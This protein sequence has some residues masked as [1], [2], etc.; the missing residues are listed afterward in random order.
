MPTRDR[1]AAGPA[2]DAAQSDE[3]APCIHML[4]LGEALLSRR[5]GASMSRTTK[6]IATVVVGLGLAGIV[7]LAILRVASGLQ[8]KWALAA[9]AAGAILS[10]VTAV[11]SSWVSHGGNPPPA[12]GQNQTVANSRL[13]SRS[14]H[15]FA[16][17]H[18]VHVNSDP[19][20]KRE[21]RSGGRS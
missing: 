11:G 7:F 8:G 16:N 6:W 10:L 17:T 12:G 1:P 20:Q 14:G 21:R 9:A 15:I 19:P 18:D 5:R 2:I 4:T 13:H 3:F